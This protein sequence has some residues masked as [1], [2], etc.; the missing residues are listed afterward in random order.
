MARE[1]AI[2]NKCEGVT[3]RGCLTFR[4]CA[5][6]KEFVGVITKS[7]ILLGSGQELRKKLRSDHR[8][9]PITRKFARTKKLSQDVRTKE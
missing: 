8:E 6:K 9:Y 4:K 3:P 2:I 1:C 5:R 7:V